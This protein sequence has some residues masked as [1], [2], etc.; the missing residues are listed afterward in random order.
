MEL[1]Q[2][3]FKLVGDTGGSIC[4]GGDVR[5]PVD[6][7]FN[8]RVTTNE[9]VSIEVIL[10]RNVTSESVVLIHSIG[11]DDYW[12]VETAKAYVLPALR[13]RMVLDELA[14]I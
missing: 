14:G 8:I 13:R 7:G 3:C 2:R 11:G 9:L 5:V 12:D 4:K 6:S 1:I 10:E